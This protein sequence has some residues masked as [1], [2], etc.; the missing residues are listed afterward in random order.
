M[1][2]SLLDIFHIKD[3][4]ND[5]AKTTIDTTEQISKL[6]AYFLKQN[7]RIKNLKN[8]ALF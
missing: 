6:A 7:S 8:S 4:N 1:S 3:N 2:C 5:T